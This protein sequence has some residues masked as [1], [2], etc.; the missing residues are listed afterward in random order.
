MMAARTAMMMV[1][2]MVDNLVVK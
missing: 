1:A 2:V